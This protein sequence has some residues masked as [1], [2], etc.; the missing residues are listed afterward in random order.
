MI[1]LLKWLGSLLCQEPEP[2]KVLEK[3][4]IKKNFK[5]KKACKAKGKKCQK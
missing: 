3:I 4:E 2:K 5:K 1:K